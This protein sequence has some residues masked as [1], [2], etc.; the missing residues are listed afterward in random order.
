MRDIEKIVT[1]I[2][3]DPLQPI[4]GIPV[5]YRVLV[6]G[7]PRR[8]WPIPQTAREWRELVNVLLAG[9]IY[10]H[11]AG[12]NAVQIVPRVQKQNTG[13]ESQDRAH[14]PHPGWNLKPALHVS[15]ALAA[16]YLELLI[17]MRRYRSCKTCGNDIS[18]QRDDSTY[19]GKP[20]TCRSKDWH[21][22]K[23]R[24]KK[25]E[26]ASLRKRLILSGSLPYERT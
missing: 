4:G 25:L 21:R 18:H 7:E 10:D 16:Y 26:M 15:S 2:E 6:N 17:V 22:E 12:P 14:E 19:C 24:G 3:T 20:S 11:V 13:E 1:F 8:A 23:S 5:H 9:Y